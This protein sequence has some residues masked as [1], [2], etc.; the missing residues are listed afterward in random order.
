MDMEGQ[1]DIEKILE[2]CFAV[3]GQ[4]ELGMELHTEGGILFMSES[5]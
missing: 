1:F 4:N 3:L 5:P 2:D